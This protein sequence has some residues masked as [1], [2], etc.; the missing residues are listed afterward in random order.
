MSERNCKHCRFWRDPAAGFVEV[1]WSAKRGECMHS[2]VP[3]GVP[4]TL[5]SDGESCPD[6]SEKDGLA[7][8]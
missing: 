5:P 8:D 7:E 2:A 1:Y 4:Y 3:L 6:W